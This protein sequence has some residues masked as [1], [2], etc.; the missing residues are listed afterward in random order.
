MGDIKDS[1]SGL[2]P[3][4]Y[5]EVLTGIETSIKE[6]TPVDYSN[7]LDTLNTTL[8]NLITAVTTLSTNLTTSL[9][10]ISGKIDNLCNII[11][12]ETVTGEIVQNTIVGQIVKLNQSNESMANNI[13]HWHHD[14][15]R[16]NKR[17]DAI[18]LASLT[19]GDRV[20]PLRDT[21]LD[22]NEPNIKY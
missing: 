17:L 1:L 18:T 22:L 6:N 19:H 20:A 8:T 14:F 5:S 13:E 11:Y 3:I 12:R 2:V 15:H 10:N 9:S 21:S 16:V 7:S 4:N